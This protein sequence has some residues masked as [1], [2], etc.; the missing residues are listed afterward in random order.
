MYPRDAIR[1]VVSL[2]RAGVL[3]LDAEVASFPLERV[4]DAVAH[5]A[6]TAGPFKATVLCRD[7]VHLAG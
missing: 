1:R 5:A 7:R 2:V 4:A 6:A 3:R